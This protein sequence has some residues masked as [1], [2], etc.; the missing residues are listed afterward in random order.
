MYRFTKFLPALPKKF[1]RNLFANGREPLLSLTTVRAG[2]PVFIPPA[3]KSLTMEG[4][5]ARW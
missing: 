1:E 5:D 4:L 2:L 3:L